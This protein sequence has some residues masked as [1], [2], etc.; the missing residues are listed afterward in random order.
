MPSTTLGSGRIPGASDA[1]LDLVAEDAERNAVG[2][3]G[4]RGRHDVATGERRPRRGQLV[5]RVLERD[6]PLGAAQHRDGGREEPVV[7]TDEHAVLHLDGDAPSLGS[8]PG[9]DDR[10][11]EPFGEVLHRSRERERTGAHVER[12]NVVRDV[13]HAQLRCEVG[14]HRVADTDELV[15]APVVGEKRDE[16]GTRSHRLLTLSSA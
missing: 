15:T 4:D 13:E 6:D 10:E 12:C 5:L 8:D 14:H 7:G 1:A 11:H 16:V 9:I 2:D 3:V